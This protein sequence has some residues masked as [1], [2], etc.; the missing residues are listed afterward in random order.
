MRRGFSSSDALILLIVEC[1]SLASVAWFTRK[2]FYFQDDFVFLRQ[3]GA[4]KFDLSYLRDQLFQ[5]FSPVSRVGDYL[6]F[7]DFNDSFDVAKIAILLMYGAS[8]MAFAW[9]IGAFLASPYRHM[10]TFVFAESLAMVHIAGWWTAALNIMPATI[11]GLCTIAAYGRYRTGR[12]TQYGVGAVVF[13]AASLLT[14]EQSWLVFGYLAL[15]EILIV[16]GPLR[17]RATPLRTRANYWVWSS[18]TALTGLAISNYMAFYYVPMKP[19]PTVMQML[20]FLGV[21]F[22]E[23]LSPSLTGFR[24]LHG[25]GVFTFAYLLDVSLVVLA[26][27]VTT[28]LFRGAWRAWTVFAI[29]FLANGLM[30]GLNR[31]GLYGAD[32]GRSML[33]VQAPQYLFMLCLGLACASGAYRFAT[34]ARHKAGGGGSRSPLLSRRGRFLIVAVPAVLFFGSFLYSAAAQQAQDPNDKMAQLSGSYIRNLEDTTKSLGSVVV[35]KDTAVP[36]E[37]VLSNFAPYNKLSSVAIV[38]Q[39]PVRVGPVGRA[40]AEVQADGKVVRLPKP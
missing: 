39:L 12:G 18:L 37:M 14:H 7:H 17:N 8:V 21:L 19:R 2:D 24:P 13:Y 32:Y 25:G 29:G 38:A 27:I 28:V 9:A 34:E 1:L 31:V 33:Y 16:G 5:H 22:G 23:A 20:D 40:N 26:I 11:L 15:I 3:A 30:I 4:S 10:L 35:L 36:N 6:L